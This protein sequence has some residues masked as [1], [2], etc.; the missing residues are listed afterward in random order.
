MLSKSFS[1]LK[2]LCKQPKTFFGFTGKTNDPFDEDTEIYSYKLQAIDNLPKIPTFRVI[3]VNG[4]LIAKEYDLK[5]DNKELFIKI[6]ETMVRLEEMDTF[7]LMSQR[8]G[9][10][11][12]YMPSF[13][14]SACVIGSAAA[15]K[16][17][18]LIWAQYR[19]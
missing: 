15:L 9:K 8:Q 10:I 12:F 5:P 2:N 6:F 1:Y 3:D 14:E 11:S 17:E 18:D 7:L 19:E 4:K 16:F 13:G